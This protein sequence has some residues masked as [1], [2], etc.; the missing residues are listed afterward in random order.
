MSMADQNNVQRG[1]LAAAER[2]G[3]QTAWSA[4]KQS[5]ANADLIG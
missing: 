1:K 3:N 4:G 5:E 2:R